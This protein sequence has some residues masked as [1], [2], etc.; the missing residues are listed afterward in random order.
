[1]YDTKCS[2]SQGCW[3]CSGRCI[4]CMKKTSFDS[5]PMIGYHD[6]SVDCRSCSINCYRYYGSGLAIS[7]ELGFQPSQ[8]SNGH[9]RVLS[10]CTS[11]VNSNLE[12]SKILVSLFLCNN[13]HDYPADKPYALFQQRHLGGAQRF[14]EFFVSNDGFEPTDLL[15]YIDKNEENQLHLDSLKNSEFSAILNAIAS[16]FSHRTLLSLLTAVVENPKAF[17]AT[18][19][20]PC[21]TRNFNYLPPGYS[22]SHNEKVVLPSNHYILLHNTI[23]YDRLHEGSVLFLVADST[24]DSFMPYVLHYE[25]SD[26]YTFAVA[27]TVDLDSLEP[28][29]P[30]IGTQLIHNE[31]FRSEMLTMGLKAVMTKLSKLLQKHDVQS[32]CALQSKI[33]TV[34]SDSLKL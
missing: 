28:S 25:Y 29:A 31:N 22:V 5:V 4:N 23:E 26:Y 6:T 19:K 9:H 21:F 12:K 11:M 27:Y 34:R 7:I 32:I 15:P 2:L 24:G 14:L 18:L 8:L 30:I 3:Y 10:F 20:I 1:M 17:P 16:H 13:S 33:R